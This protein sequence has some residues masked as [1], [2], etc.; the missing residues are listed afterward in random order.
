MN[1]YFDHRLWAL[2]SVILRVSASHVRG[3]FDKVSTWEVSDP[4]IYDNSKSIH[5]QVCEPTHVS[6]FV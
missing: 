4:Q 1:L 6:V 5:E 3:L 2:L